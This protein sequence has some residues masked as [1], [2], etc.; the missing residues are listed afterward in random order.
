MHSSSALP[1]TAQ[2]HPAYPNSNYQTRHE[3]TQRILIESRGR[4]LDIQ[5]KRVIK[6]LR[7]AGRS[8]PEVQWHTKANPLLW[9]ADAVCGAY[10]DQH[11][12]QV[13]GGAEFEEAAGLIAAT[14]F[15]AVYPTKR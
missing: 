12:S 1:Y 5:D 10:R 6:Q 14:G 4:K 2:A 9:L 11:R 15:T 7:S 13:E 3:G 8:V